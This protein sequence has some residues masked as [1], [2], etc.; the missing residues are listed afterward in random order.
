M[1]KPWRCGRRRGCRRRRD[2]RVYDS[3]PG[4]AGRALLEPEFVSR[5]QPRVRQVDA[6]DR[7]RSL[8]TG[9]NR[10]DRGSTRCSLCL[11]VAIATVS[12]RRVLASI[13]LVS[14]Y[15]LTRFQTNASA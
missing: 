10:N 1:R 15:D 12:F 5:I 7:G 4:A 6:Q 2:R 11:A 14:W 9:E 8:G 3:V 13:G